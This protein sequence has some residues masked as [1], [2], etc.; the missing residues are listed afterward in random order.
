MWGVLGRKMDHIFIFE[1]NPKGSTRTANQGLGGVPGKKK[2]VVSK[3]RE[4]KRKPILGKEE[5][6][7]GHNEGQKTMWIKKKKP[8]SHPV[9]GEKKKKPK[10]PCP[11]WMGAGA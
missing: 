6:K 2:P 11:S 9:A 7:N 5:E 4:K 1:K 8:E 3:R 10:N